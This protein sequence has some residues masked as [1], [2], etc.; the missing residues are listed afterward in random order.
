MVREGADTASTPWTMR[1]PALRR[2]ARGGGRTRG[3][4]SCR[5]QKK[6]AASLR[7]LPL[8]LVWGA[9]GGAASAPG[10]GPLRAGRS[11]GL[12][13]RGEWF[14]CKNCLLSRTLLNSK[15]RR[16]T[17]C[18]RR[19]AD[20]AATKGSAHTGR[21]HHES[22]GEWRQRRA[23]SA[24]QCGGWRRRRG[25]AQR[26][27]GVVGKADGRQVARGMGWGRAAAERRH[28]ATPPPTDGRRRG[29]ANDRRSTRGSRCTPWLRPRRCSR[30]SATPCA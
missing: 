18:A 19:A 25:A 11:G 29:T 8:R 10:A 22:P 23:A 9:D 21:K 27:K 6:T 1:V 30:Q 16:A 13:A 14:G 17:G 28:Q 15:I 5:K 20:A 12:R 26:R 4:A 3:A 24:G 2:P 7:R